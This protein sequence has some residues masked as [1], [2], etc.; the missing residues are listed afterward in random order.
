M[1]TQT[2]FDLNAAMESWRNELA[3]QPQLSSDD[4]RELEKHLADTMAELRHRGLNEEESFWLAR[5]RIGQPQVL[6]EEFVKADPAAVW[7]ERVFWMAL[8]VLIA[9]IVSTISTATSDLLCSWVP[10]IENHAGETFMSTVIWFIGIFGILAFLINGKLNGRFIPFN[11]LAQD[12]IR[13]AVVVI[14]VVLA[15]NL[16]CAGLMFGAFIKFHG[17]YSPMGASAFIWKWLTYA[18]IRDL[19]LI[20]ALI[21]FVPGKRPKFQ[22]SPKFQ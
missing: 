21:W 2:R 9:F 13:F 8:A 19:G 18:M 12:R 16:V 6:A 1:A 10:S 11:L 20:V 5:R 15:I 14:G 17:V 7:R 4:R 22:N 3:S